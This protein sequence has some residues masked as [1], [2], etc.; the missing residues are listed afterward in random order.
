GRELTMAKSPDP[1]RPYGAHLALSRWKPVIVMAALPVTMVAL[2]KILFDAAEMIQGPNPREGTLTPLQFL[3]VNLS[4]TLTGFLAVPVTA[5][6][7][8]VPWRSILSFPRAFDR[9][10]LA[11]YSGG[12]LLFV[13]LANAALGV[14][15]PDRTPWTGFGL[16]GTT[17]ALLAVAVLTTP[18]TAA[19]EELM[20]RGAIM[21]AAASWVKPPR[22]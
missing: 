6:L 16:T 13:L 9:G 17:L 1:V 21:P 22:P 7:A 4:M 12:S 3:A 2:Q 10:R 19:A 11:F 8:R 20:F 14:L 18:L 15:A 5:H